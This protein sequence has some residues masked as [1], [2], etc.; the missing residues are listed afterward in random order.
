MAPTPLTTRPFYVV[1]MGVSGCGKT[2]VG[3]ALA[4]R[5]ACE[6]LDGDVLHSP[7]NVAKMAAGTPLT[8]SDR[9]PWLQDVGQRLAAAQKAGKSFVIGCSALRRAY[10][11]LIRDQA[12]GTVFIHLDGDKETLLQ[13]V[14]VRA[15]H[16]MPAT[17]LNSQ[18]D[19]LEPLQDDETGSVVDVALSID[20]II[21]TAEEWLSSIT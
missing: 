10:R 1:V 21:D 6:F 13:R 2:S 5:M 8:D 15:G 7:E 18:L 4:E 11:D 16:F 12:P 14:S 20:E 3:L 9:F 19:T 17:L